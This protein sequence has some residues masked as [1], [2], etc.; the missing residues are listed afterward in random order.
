MLEQRL[1]ALEREVTGPAAE[2]LVEEFERVS[3]QHAAKEAAA[4]EFERLKK[5]E[6]YEKV[7][8]AR[9]AAE[10]RRAEYEAFMRARGFEP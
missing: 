4:R 10:K 6:F 9:E 3:E 7:P 2:E 1:A 8:W 5:E